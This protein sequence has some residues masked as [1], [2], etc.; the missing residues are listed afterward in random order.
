[1]KKITKRLLIATVLALVLIAVITS[2]VF[3]ADGNPD[4]GNQGEEC[5]Y[6]ECINDDCVPKEHS[7]DWN[8]YN[9]EPGP[10]RERN[11]QPAE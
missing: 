1:M 8:S 5:P 3:A 2:T 9:H 6:G 10:H 4:K 11:G 7:Y